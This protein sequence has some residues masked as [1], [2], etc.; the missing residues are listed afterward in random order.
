MGPVSS[1][2]LLLP[3]AWRLTSPDVPRFLD[4][5][6]H[7]LVPPFHLALP[8]MVSPPEEA[9]VDT[10]I[11]GNVFQSLGIPGPHTWHFV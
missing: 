10:H 9:M 7:P 2:T 5:M 6:L 4:F 1:S 8:R 11:P 3:L